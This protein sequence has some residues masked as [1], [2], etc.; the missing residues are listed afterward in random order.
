MDYVKTTEMIYYFLSLTEW[1]PVQTAMQYIISK[2]ALWIDLLLAVI[3][4]SFLF[5][6]TEVAF[7]ARIANAHVVNVNL[8]NLL[9]LK[10]EAIINDQMT[11]QK[12]SQVTYECLMISIRS[13]GNRCFPV[14]FNLFYPID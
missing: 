2:L 10:W 14:I 13:T 5:W 4:N 3:T 9:A 7:I 8:Q 6:F 1:L 11:T 12:S